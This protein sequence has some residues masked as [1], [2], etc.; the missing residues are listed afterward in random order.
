MVEEKP[1]ANTALKITRKTPTTISCVSHHSV[2]IERPRAL[3]ICLMKLSMGLESL[4]TVDALDEF[5]FI[6][7]LLKVG[8]ALADRPVERPVQSRL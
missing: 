5:V 8:A 7:G 2:R 4:A 1:L 3:K 6:T